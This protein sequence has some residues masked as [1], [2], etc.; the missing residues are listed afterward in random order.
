MIGPNDLFIAEARRGT[1][2]NDA[3]EVVGTAATRTNRHAFLYGAG[4]MH[5]LGTIAGDYIEASSIN[6]AGQVMTRGKSSA[7]ARRR[8]RC[9]PSC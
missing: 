1:A 3:G 6:A 8:A 4:R 5:D 7:S 2:I 9:A